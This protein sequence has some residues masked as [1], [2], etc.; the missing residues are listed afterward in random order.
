MLSRGRAA[1]AFLVALGLVALSGLAPRV[2]ATPQ[3][4]APTWIGGDGLM[5]IQRTNPNGP[6]LLSEGCLVEAADLPSQ[7]GRG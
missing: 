3:L 1:G 5:V 4:P 2:A 6:G 7:S